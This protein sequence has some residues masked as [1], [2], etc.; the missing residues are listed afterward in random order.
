M[1]I[2]ILITGTEFA[3]GTKQDT[4]STMFAKMAFEHGLDVVFIHICKDDEIDITKN[5]QFALEFCDILVVSGGLGPTFDDVT[6]EALS[7]A[8]D[9]PLVYDEDWLDFL[10]KD[11]KSRNVELTQMRKR[12]ALRLSNSKPIPNKF[13]KA[14]GF[15]YEKNNKIVIAL[16]GIPQEAKSMLNY[17]LNAL[18]HRDKIREVKLFRT[19]GIKES[20]VSNLVKD[21]KGTFINVSACGVDVY[22]QD[23]VSDQI[24][25]ILG[26]YIYSD[27]NLEMEEVLGKLLREKKL[28]IATAESS[29]GGLIVSRLVNVAGSSDYCLGSV[30]SY[31]NQAK[32]DILGVKQQT[33]ELYGAVSEQT[34]KEMLLGAKKLTNADIVLCDTGIAG[35]GGGSEEKPIGLHYIGIM[36]KNEVKI[37]KEIYQG[38]RNYTRLYISQYALNLARL[39]LL[40]D[41]ELFA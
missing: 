17:A 21:Y 1:N 7:T 33:L 22:V 30:V 19:F 15:F 40:N 39:A 24:K 13:G 14:I 31:S 11:Y 2:G 26:K 37:F 34:A 18:G 8:L 27:D 10:K 6:R 4:N 25:S 12:M 3:T 38:E 20:D 28:T 32:M 5:V 36:F 16:P 23:A 41:D 35:P 29:T 9:E